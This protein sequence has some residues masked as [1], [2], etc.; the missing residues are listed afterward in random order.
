MKN[1]RTSAKDVRGQFEVWY[2]WETDAR[3]VPLT[4]ISGPEA[5]K[6]A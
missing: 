2:C 6:K 5:P 3:C 1:P 4:R